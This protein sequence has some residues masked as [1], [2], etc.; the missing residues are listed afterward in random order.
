MRRISAVLFWLGA[1]TLSTH[2]AVPISLSRDDGAGQLEISYADQRICVYSF[3]PNQFK[4]YVKELRTLAGDNVLL[5]SPADHLHHHG[6]MYAIRVNGINFWEE[7]EPAGKEKH[8]SINAAS[9]CANGATFSELIHWLEPTNSSSPLLVE[10]REI[11]L[12]INDPQKEVVLRWHSKFRVGA[13]SVKLNG[14]AY[15]GLGMRFPPAWNRTAAH[16]NSEDLPYTIEHKWDVTPARW[17]ALYHD[18][19][20]FKSTVALFGN[21]KNP[22]ETRFFSMNNPFAYLSV[23]E[24][25]EQRPIEYEPGAEFE[26]N[27][28]VLLYSEPKPCSFLND[29][30]DQWLSERSSK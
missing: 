11:T 16:R 21:R 19:A 1:I 10:N 18:A 29:R 15:N 30:Y 8:I 13:R 20:G 4:P 6:L 12:T 17:A 3:K 23:T 2:A 28:I 24:N 14:T 25:L 7:V 9:T 27:Y 5:D 26:L 22:G